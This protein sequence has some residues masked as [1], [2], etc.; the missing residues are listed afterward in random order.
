MHKLLQDLGLCRR[1]GALCFGTDATK[2]AVMNKKGVLIVCSTFLSEKSKKEMRFLSE[3]SGTALY[4]L[5]HSFEEIGAIV[6][7]PVGV[8][9]ITNASLAEKFLTDADT[10]QTV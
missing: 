2:E 6:G 9:C 7:K 3:K 5:S 4:M 1:A 8:L 10:Q